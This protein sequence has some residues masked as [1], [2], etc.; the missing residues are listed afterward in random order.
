M[1]LYLLPLQCNQKKQTIMKANEIKWERRDTLWPMGVWYLEKH[2]W[3]KKEAKQAKKYL[4]PETNAQVKFLINNFKPTQEIAMNYCGVNLLEHFLHEHMLHGEY[5]YNEK[6]DT[7]VLINKDVYIEALSR[8]LKNY[9][10][11]KWELKML[12]INKFNETFEI[13]F[14]K[15]TKK[16]LWEIWESYNNGFNKLI[17]LKKIY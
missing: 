16:E 15:P 11:H 17:S 1:G 13:S 2:C 14:I 5:S 9:K 7:A 12:H 8:K 3:Y 4:V 6:N 10:R